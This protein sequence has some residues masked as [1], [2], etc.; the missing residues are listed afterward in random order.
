MKD[1]AKAFM[2][3]SIGILALV[4]AFQFEV[5]TSRADFDESA[6]IRVVGLGGNGLVALLADGTVFAANASHD[7][8]EDDSSPVPV[9]V[10]SIAFW[11]GSNLVTN[12]DECW[13]FDGAWEQAPSLP[14][15]VRAQDS[16][17]SQVKASYK[18]D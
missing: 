14:G 13:I 7:W 12:S 16:S 11:N 4:V 1:K 10:A 17:W 2:F 8:Y 5:R 15:A 3:V 9:S 6:A 18:D